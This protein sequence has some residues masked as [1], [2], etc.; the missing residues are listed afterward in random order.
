VQ[1]IADSLADPKMISRSCKTEGVT[2]KYSQLTL[3]DRINIYLGLQQNFSYQKIA[4]QLGKD[5]S[6][7]SREVKRN[8]GMLK[9]FLLMYIPFGKE[10]FMKISMD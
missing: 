7:I 4:E 6:T 10:L 8:L 3:D 9:Y 1:Q 2:M 5:K